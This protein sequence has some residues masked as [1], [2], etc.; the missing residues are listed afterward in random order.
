M[1]ALTFSTGVV[2]A[3]GYLGLDRVFTGNMTGNVVIL[4]MAIADPSSKL[5]VIGPLLALACFLI[6]AAIAGRVFRGVPAGWYLRTTVLLGGVAAVL[7]A[8]AILGFANQTRSEGLAYVI[9]GMLGLA[10][11]AQAGS[12]RH[13]GVADVTT[14]VVTST[15]V[16][17][18]FDSRFGGSKSKHPWQKR[19]G[20]ILLLALGAASGALLLRADI[21]FGMLLAAV[22]TIA[23]VILGTL[24]RPQLVDG[25][26]TN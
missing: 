25:D 20:A 14:V 24:G 21:G 26:P 4:A 17:L 3:V 12:A 13:I 2:D 8:A 5:P 6:G 19:S 9:T 22:I 11:G 15:L 7:T 10:M 1:L 16:G 18:A 23:V